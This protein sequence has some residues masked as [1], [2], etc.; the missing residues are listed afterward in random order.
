MDEYY[1]KFICSCGNEMNG[2]VDKEDTCD[3]LHCACGLVW[4]VLKPY[5]E[6]SK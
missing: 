5:K 6:E 1:F 2:V 3:E 4:P